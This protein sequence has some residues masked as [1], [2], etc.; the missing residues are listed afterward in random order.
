MKLA[1]RHEDLSMSINKVIIEFNKK[2]LHVQHIVTSEEEEHPLL[3]KSTKNIEKETKVSIF[4]F[5]ASSMPP[6]NN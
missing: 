2:R 6:S 1:S 5:S 4:F 3:V